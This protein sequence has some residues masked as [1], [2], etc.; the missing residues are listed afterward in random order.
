MVGCLVARH[1][2]R[3][4][5]SNANTSNSMPSGSGLQEP[6]TPLHLTV[7]STPGGDIFEGDVTKF[8]SNAPK[9]DSGL[10]RPHYVDDIAPAPPSAQLGDFLRRPVIIN[11]FSWTTA[12]A[13]FH[14]DPWVAFLNDAT[15]AAK[16]ATFRYIRG[17]L[18]VSIQING[19]PFHFGRIMASYEPCNWN[20]ISADNGFRQ[21]SGCQ[22]VLLDPGANTIADFRCPFVSPFNWMD[23]TGGSA[24]I[25]NGPGTTLNSNQ[26]A[27]IG[28]MNYDIIAALAIF[29][30]GTPSSV[31]VLT[32]AWLDDVQLAMPTHSTKIAFLPQ[33]GDEYTLSP[34]SGLISGPSAV[35]SSVAKRLS[36]APYIGPY[37][38][39][40]SIA[41]GA[42]SSMAKLFG[43]SKPRSLETTTTM[44]QGIAGNMPNV[45]MADSSVSLTYNAKSEIAVGPGITGFDPGCD[46]LS[47]QAIAGRWTAMRVIPWA[48]T[49]T[50]GTQLV[51]LGISP[52]MFSTV[53]VG[54]YAMSSMCFA[55]LP[56]AKWAG[57]IQIRMVIM[58]SRFHRGRLRVMWS[59]STNTDNAQN[60]T[61]NQ[62]I[63]ISAAT[64]YCVTFPYICPEGYK[65]VSVPVATESYLPLRDSGSFKLIVQNRLVCP[66][67][68]PIRILFYVRAGPDMRFAVPHNAIQLLSPYSPITIGFAAEEGASSEPLAAVDELPDEEEEFV[69][70]SGSLAELGVSA[71]VDCV[72]ITFI[73]NPPLPNHD[74]A[75]MGDPIISFRALM[76]RY[77]NT[78]VLSTW[79]GSPAAG[80]Y[81]SRYTWPLYP[82]FR[83]LVTTG[84]WTV[85]GVDSHLSNT[86]LASYLSSA[87]LGRRGGFRTLVDHRID[88]GNGSTSALRVYRHEEG[89]PGL[90]LPFSV[91]VF[92]TA[93][94]NI[95]EARSWFLAQQA[96]D[97]AGGGQ[98]YPVDAHGQRIS[99]ETPFYSAF[100]YVSALERGQLASG[101]IG[102]ASTQ[103]NSSTSATLDIQITQVSSPAIST[104]LWLYQAAAEDFNLF[105]Y[106]GIPIMYAVAP[107][108]VPADITQ[109]YNTTP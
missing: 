10:P 47:V 25:P 74:L 61:Y 23:M 76:K 14:I 9:I 75:Y 15:V 67:T 19:T 60:L 41:A 95:I 83:K 77:T 68:E 65:Q 105:F 26:T 52:M 107:I 18:H 43:Y 88:P 94:A 70:Q 81:H 24:V 58:A 71:S 80:N 82:H 5:K 101:L 46:E 20:R 27:A 64:E 85:S 49:S 17:T 63:D 34:H 97:F 109:A 72:D 16:L 4:H 66:S 12:T 62:I 92:F 39:A 28:V 40:T 93:I 42:L 32:Y 7:E 108:L 51:Q 100:K 104:N 54:D 89:N 1:F 6:T 13:S 87:F 8:E 33:A 36:G 21:H 84:L 53:A 69:R 90:G 22:H 57:S 102:A 37:A 86:H 50:T 35:I 73:P 55:S 98:L 11:S 78:T 30:G 48:S 56:F 59:P 44:V 3:E 96:S 103:P 106:R 29:Q 31:E 2:R 79:A 45:D 91:N 38:Q 99:V